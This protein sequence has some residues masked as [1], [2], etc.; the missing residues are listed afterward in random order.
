MAF[1]DEFADLMSSTLIAQP[2]VQN[3]F[4]DWSAS[5]ESISIPCRIEYE[6]RLVRTPEGNEVVSSYQA[7]CPYTGLDVNTHRFTLPSRYSPRV[8]LRA[9]N[10]VVEIDDDDGGVPCYE[11]VQF[12]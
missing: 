3:G 12:K 5:G 11:E 9:I 10:I 6:Q 8:D 4:G 2:G 7:I 1:I